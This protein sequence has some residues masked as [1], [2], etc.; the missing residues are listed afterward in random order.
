MT[1]NRQYHASRA[2]FAGYLIAA[3][4]NFALIYQVG[5]QRVDY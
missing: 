2:A 4:G 5:L 3:T 1:G